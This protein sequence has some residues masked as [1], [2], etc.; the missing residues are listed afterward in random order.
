[1]SRKSEPAETPFSTR[2]CTAI[3]CRKCRARVRWYRRQSLAGQQSTPSEFSTE[4]SD[5]PMTVSIPLV[6]I[7]GI[8][9]T[10]L[11]ATWVFAYGTQL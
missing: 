7:F 11:T 8:S 2:H 6:A 1:M 9:C 3:N 5:D 4:R 10:S